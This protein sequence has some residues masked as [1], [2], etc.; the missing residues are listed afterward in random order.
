M[1]DYSPYKQCAD[2]GKT[3]SV[4]D[5][6]KRCQKCRGCPKWKGLTPEYQRQYRR[7]LQA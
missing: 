5:A 2:C 3:M 4:N 1:L 6:H 7:A